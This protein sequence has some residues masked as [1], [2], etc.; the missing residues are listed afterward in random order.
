VSTN[1]PARRSLPMRLGERGAPIFEDESL[2]DSILIRRC[3]GYLIDLVLLSC[4]AVVVWT[5]LGLLG[6]LSF[7]IL[8]PL[9]AIALALLPV[10]YHTL[11]IGA[12]GATPGMRLLDLEVRSLDGQAP[13]YVQ[14][15]VM[16]AVFY[17]SISATAWLV[18]L[19]ALFNERRRTLHDF[20]SGTV[21]VR[22]A[23]VRSLAER[24]AVV[25]R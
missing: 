21:V 19:V 3:F 22:R 9:Q 2:Y 15:L 11:F 6:I 13:D 18:L 16:T 10:G 20:L 25:R 12:Q 8:L 4:L 23:T 14:A 1:L 17:V 24:Q 5:T 7:G